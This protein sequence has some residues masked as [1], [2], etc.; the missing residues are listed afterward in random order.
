MAERKVTD[1]QLRV[2]AYVK[3]QIKKNTTTKDSVRTVILSSRVL[4]IKL[5]DVRLI[6]S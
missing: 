6:M 5:P 2:L 4:W 1:K 3:D